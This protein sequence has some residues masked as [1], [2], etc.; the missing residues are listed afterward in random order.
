MRNT[1]LWFPARAQVNWC[2]I[3]MRNCQRLLGGEE[4]IETL[5]QTTRWGGGVLR[6]ERG[7]RKG[8]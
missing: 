6:E 8:T 5:I 2:Q 3:N 4:E 1:R 7:E